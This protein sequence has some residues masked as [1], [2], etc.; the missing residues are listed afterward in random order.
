MAG[1]SAMTATKL[2]KNTAVLWAATVVEASDTGY[3]YLD[4]S[5][6][7]GSKVVFNIS[8]VG[9]AAE[10][11]VVMAGSTGGLGTYEFTAEG[12]GNYSKATTVAGGYL[13]GPFEMARFKTTDG[14]IKFKSSTASTGVINVR[15]FV[16]P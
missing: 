7:D 1:D 11:L 4:V 15:A 16:L 9:A 13:A 5:T 10:T 3:A 14:Y 8:R 12:I 2:V 6:M